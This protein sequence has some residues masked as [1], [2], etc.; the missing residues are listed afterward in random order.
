MPVPAASLTPGALVLGRYRPIRP[1]GSG[2]AGSVWLALI[3]E[4]ETLTAVGDIPGT[5]AYISPERLGGEK[6]G[7]AADVW[8]VGVMLWEGLAGTHPFWGGTL[9]ETAKLIESG[10]PPLRTQRPDL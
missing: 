6:A 9:L 10:A 7:P 4:D 2:G 8:S 3:R 1:L 5:L